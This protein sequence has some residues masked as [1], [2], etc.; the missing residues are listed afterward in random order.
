[1][2]GNDGGIVAQGSVNERVISED[3]AVCAI[4]LAAYDDN[5]ELRELPCSH[6]LPKY[7]VD[8]WLRIKARCPLC[9]RVIRRVP[10]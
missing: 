10:S 4:C 6:L 1:M 7:C 9:S 8:R 2:G 5:D 3:E